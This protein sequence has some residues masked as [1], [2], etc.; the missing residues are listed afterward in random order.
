MLPLGQPDNGRVE[1]IPTAE[2]VETAKACL[3]ERG[4]PVKD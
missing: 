3:R 2:T 4:V 1:W